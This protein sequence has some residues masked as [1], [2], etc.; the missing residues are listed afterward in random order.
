MGDR[1]V[2][3]AVVSPCP[4]ALRQPGNFMIHSTP[5]NGKDGK[6]EGRTTPPAPQQDGG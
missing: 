1:L 2:I 4:Q 5:M 3:P 6:M